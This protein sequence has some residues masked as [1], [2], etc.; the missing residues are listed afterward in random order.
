MPERPAISAGPVSLMDEGKHYSIPLSALYFDAN[1]KLKADRWPLYATLATPV[2]LF[3]GQLSTSGAVVAGP[4]PAAKPAFLVSASA[5]GSTGNA[6]TLLIENVTADTTTPADSTADITVSETDTYNG[7][8]PDS[9]TEV[10]GESAGAG[11]KP[12]LV[13]V[14]SASPEL[15]KAGSYTLASANP[16]TDPATIDIPKESGAGD[17]FTLEARSNAEDGT[18][19][20]IEIKDVDATEA[21][22]NM[23][24]SWSKNETVVKVSE[25]A[26]A[27]AYVVTITAPDGGYRAP[28]PGLIA[29]TGG[30]DAQATPAAKA[31][32]TAVAA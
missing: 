1:G 21:T 10:I 23:E 17:A 6:I 28:A 5:P 14:S 20:K 31:S 13:F 15:P 3:L 7:L 9:L 16:G 8:T 12:G 30:A 29:L 4:E 19:T 25:F 32:A 18:L 11:S 26:A 27:F 24:V 22:F 2:D